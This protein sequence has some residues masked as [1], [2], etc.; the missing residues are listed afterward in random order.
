MRETMADWL[1]KEGKKEGALEESRR[2]LLRLLQN[3]LGNV[4]ARVKTTINTTQ[5]LEQLSVWFDR[6]LDAES[7]AEIGIGTPR[8]RG[9]RNS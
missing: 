9:R 4:P 2:K 8:N 5:D 6:A 3:R 1:K 7:L